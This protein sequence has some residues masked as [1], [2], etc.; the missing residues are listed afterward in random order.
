MHQDNL[1]LGEVKRISK[2]QRK[3]IFGFRAY[4]STPTRKFEVLNVVGMRRDS[5]YVRSFTPTIEL[6]I[7]VYAIDYKRTIYPNRKNLSVIL[8]MEQIDPLSDMF[9][10]GG[11]K[12]RSSYK[13]FVVDN[14]DMSLEP[15]KGGMSKIQT[16]GRD[17]IRIFTVQLADSAAVY[18]SAKRGGS[19]F[20]FTSAFNAMA[21]FILAAT[22]EPNQA[23]VKQVMGLD[24]I[25]A[26]VTKPRDTIIMDHKVPLIDVPA[27]MQNNAGGIYNHG[28]GSFIQN[29]TWFV[30]P[31]FNT[32]R[33]ADSERRL[34]VFQ[35]PSN[36][37][38]FGDST[39][40]KIGKSVKIVCSGAANLNDTSVGAE[41]S[42]G[43]GVRF[44]HARKFIDKPTTVEN[45]QGY[46]NRAS[47]LAEINVVQR[48]DGITQAPFSDVK[49][50]DNV[51]R[52][53]SKISIRQGQVFD[54]LWMNANPNLVTP[55]MP[56]KVYYDNGGKIC[57]LEGVV[58]S[59]SEKWENSQPGLLSK[60]LNCVVELKLFVAKP[61]N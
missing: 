8:S 28:I 57:S 46:F 61:T 12:V 15:G 30:Y 9:L 49:A 29:N 7:A 1:L 3:P 17:E 35:I 31:L 50:T 32:K 10:D 37:I 38:P 16:D 53:L 34:T 54:T 20:R 55:G 22:K 33:Y 36:Y 26:D 11:L 41:I 18:A 42:E 27:W 13:A 23:D 52:E 48:E 47:N 44:I 51:A 24:M 59:M 14:N 58:L 39:W 2:L 4:V 19:T 40:E 25:P 45:N 21:T 6:Q 43:T 56:V 60:K 5:D